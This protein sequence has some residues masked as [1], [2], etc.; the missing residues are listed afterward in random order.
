MLCCVNLSCWKIT[1]VYIVSSTV[2]EGPLLYILTNNKYLLLQ[3]IEVLTTCSS[4]EQ[5]TGSPKSLFFL[6]FTFLQLVRLSCFWLLAFLLRKL[7]NKFKNWLS[8]HFIVLIFLF[9][10]ALLGIRSVCHMLWILFS[11]S[12]IS[13]LTVFWS[14]EL[15]SF[16]FIYFYWAITYSKAK[17]SDIQLNYFLHYYI[18]VTTTQIKIQYISNKGREIAFLL[19]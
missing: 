13:S 7:K 17:K 19:K 14:L 11:F 5:D 9:I 12:C 6:K 18:Y 4:V 15:L 10:C 3:E 16:L 2:G 8:I 1:S